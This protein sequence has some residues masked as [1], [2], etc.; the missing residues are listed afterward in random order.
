M[1]K[2]TATAHEEPNQSS[3]KIPSEGEH[4]FQVVDFLDSND[5]NI[6]LV[7]AE[8]VGGEEEGISLINRLSLDDNWKGF[9]ATR[10]FLK[11]VGEEYKGENFT[12]DTD[13]WVGKQ[14]YATVIHS[15]YKGKTYANIDEYNYEK[16][17]EQY[18]KSPVKGE[19]VQW[20]DDK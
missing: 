7:K 13:N 12:I 18:S 1:V 15:E 16:K 11:A 4:L 8:V 3:F 2:R 14:F 20:D 17:I 9:F 10:L 19:E 5:P 6:V